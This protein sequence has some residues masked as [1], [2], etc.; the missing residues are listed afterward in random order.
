MIARLILLLLLLLPLPAAA[1]QPP[2]PAEVPLGQTLSGRFLEGSWGL[3][4]SG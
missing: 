4:L 3:R 2:R 1:Q